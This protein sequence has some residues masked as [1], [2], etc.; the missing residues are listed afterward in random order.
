M[1]D[2][3]Q[4]IYDTVQCIEHFKG[5]GTISTLL[6][7]TADE[8]KRLQ[9]E[10]KKKEDDND[11]RPVSDWW[12]T[13]RDDLTVQWS[14]AQLWITVGTGNERAS[15]SVLDNPTYGDVRRLL[16]CLRVPIPMGYAPLEQKNT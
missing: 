14:P 9:E 8:I 5:N 7:E 16:E 15:L 12:S 10:L 2:I 13:S 11:D 4:K 3:L 1:A 6:L